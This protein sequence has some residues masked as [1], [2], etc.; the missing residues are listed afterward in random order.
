MDKPEEST[1]LQRIIEAL[2]KHEALLNASDKGTIEIHFSGSKENVSI[3][4]IVQ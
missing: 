4:F 2:T 1:R 3:K